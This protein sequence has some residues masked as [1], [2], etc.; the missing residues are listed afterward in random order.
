M[1]KFDDCVT[2]L[3][4][5]IMRMGIT[6]LYGVEKG[7][8]CVVTRVE[9]LREETVVRTMRRAETLTQW[10]SGRLQ[11]RLVFRSRGKEQVERKESRK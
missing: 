10:L 11:T 2:L 8:L 7:Y 4:G 3:E 9:R 6:N 1:T 5:A